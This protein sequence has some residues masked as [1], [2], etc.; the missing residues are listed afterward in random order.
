MG[1]HDADEDNESAPERDHGL[2]TGGERASSGA[3][4][5]GVPPPEEQQRQAELLQQQPRDLFAV[6]NLETGADDDAV[7]RAY[8]LLSRA[9]HPDKQPPGRRREE[10]QEVFVEI[11]NACK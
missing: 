3:D 6:L 8:K 5:G 11:K 7:Q 2:G 9:F 1:N 10:A 4:S